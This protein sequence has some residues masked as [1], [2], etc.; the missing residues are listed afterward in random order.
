MCGHQR[1][2]LCQA[3]APVDDLICSFAGELSNEQAGIRRNSSG[4]RLTARF[5]QHDV[6]LSTG[7]PQRSM[8]TV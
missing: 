4:L 6:H 1:P 5:A 7:M 8:I 2:G 3:V